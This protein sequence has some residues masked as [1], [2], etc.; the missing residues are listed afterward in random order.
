ME[1]LLEGKALRGEVFYD[2]AMAMEVVLFNGLICG[3]GRS[4]FWITYRHY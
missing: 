3:C 2:G 1:N 4:L